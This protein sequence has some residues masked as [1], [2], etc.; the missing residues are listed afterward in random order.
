MVDADRPA[1]DRSFSGSCLPLNSSRVSWGD[2]FFPTSPPASKRS[3]ISWGG[4]EWLRSPPRARHSSRV[5][6]SLDT[7]A[8]HRARSVLKFVF[9][10]KF[11]P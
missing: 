3:V 9:R 7:S 1:C 11:G 4:T 5:D 10:G 2:E 8:R 6:S